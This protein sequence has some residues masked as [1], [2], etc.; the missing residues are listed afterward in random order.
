M[1]AFTHALEAI[2]SPDSNLFSDGFAFAAAEAILEYLPVAVQDGQNVLARS[3]MLQASTMAITAFTHT[4]GGMPVHN[5]SH[6]FGGMF[7]VPHGDAN[8][9]LL[10]IVIESLPEFYEP[11]AERL[12]RA[13]NIAVNGQ[14][15]AELL[16]DVVDRVRDFQTEIGCHTSMA[17]WNL[18]ESDIEGVCQAVAAD[19][20]AIFYPL[21][22]SAIEQVVIKAIG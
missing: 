14:S 15:R 20:T 8:A 6:A 12:C 21:P 19:S 17:P 3:N 11:Q 22:R 16:A 10:P 4:L 5:F 7:H 1:D 18:T 2:A 13:L 9:I